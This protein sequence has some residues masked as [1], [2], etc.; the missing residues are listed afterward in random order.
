MGRRN[1]CSIRWD[2]S[3]GELS[4]DIRVE[5]QKGVG[6]TVGYAPFSQASPG[7]CQTLTYLLAVTSLRR[8]HPV[9]VVEDWR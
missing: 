5:K 1:W 6:E 2:M 9:G 8:L 3:S 7:L 4:F